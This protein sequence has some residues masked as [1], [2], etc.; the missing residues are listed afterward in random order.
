MDGKS[1]LKVPSGI[2]SGKLLRMRGKGFPM[3][4]SSSKGDQIVRVVV[5]TPESISRHSKKIIESLK[6]ELSP[7]KNPFSKID[8]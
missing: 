7:I 1:T 4:R 8:L 5:D 3:L 2:Q 6:S